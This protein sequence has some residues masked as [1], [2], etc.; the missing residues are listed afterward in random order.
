M[1]KL[2][3]ITN[4]IDGSGGLE[5]VLSVKASLLTD[6]YNYEVTI[7]VLN[8]NDSK[9][10]YDFSPKIKIYPVLASGN[11]IQF[12][13][14]YFF[15]I[16][17]AIKNTNPDIVL[18]CDDGFKGFLIPF[19]TKKKTPI[20]YERHASIYLHSNKESSLFKRIIT[21]FQI[22]LMRQLAKK[23]DYFVVLTPSN[24]LEW[25][26]KNCIAIP[27]P[28]SFNTASSAALSNKQ[29]IA[30][31]NHSY[32]K[33]LD[34]LLQSW[35]QVIAQFPDWK[36]VVYGKF[37]HEETYIKMT[38]ELHLSSS[39]SF[40]KPTTAIIDAYLQSS[41]FV[42]P[43]RSEGFGMVLIEA[44]AC[45][46]PCVSFDCPSGPSDIIAHNE[47]GFLVANGDIATF[48]DKIKILIENENLRQKMGAKAKQNVARYKPEAIV[49]QWDNLFKKLLK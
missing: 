13:K 7:V 4:G 2:V 31:G 28:L 22:F 42:L 49:Q 34:R 16:K 40:Y 38:K 18:V 43:S 36:L 12:Y 47:D 25:K 32:N 44:M 1:V 9:L 17:Q 27:N 5:R 30:V 19:L 33:G 21:N 23:F 48:A 10:F 20:L 8:P 29:V 39:V 14:Q 35:Q 24:I 45:G 15:G 6:T 3:Y 46:V 37:D 41:I 26:T 11:S